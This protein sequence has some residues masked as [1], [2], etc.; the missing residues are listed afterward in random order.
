MFPPESGYETLVSATVTFSPAQ[1]RQASETRPFCR[2]DGCEGHREKRVHLCNQSMV[3]E[4]HNRS[5]RKTSFHLRIAHS[6][7]QMAEMLVFD[8]ARAIAIDFTF[9]A[10]LMMGS[11]GT[12]TG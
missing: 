6:V 2:L 12:A 4:I 10:G 1:H 3:G 5:H 8:T 9:Q 7:E 11:G